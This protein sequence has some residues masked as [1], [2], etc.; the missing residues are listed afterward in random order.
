MT[1]TPES[2]VARLERIMAI[3]KAIYK[4][5]T[6]VELRE[7]QAKLAEELKRK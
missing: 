5:Q 7:W 1:A 4:V 2:R 6:E 3:L